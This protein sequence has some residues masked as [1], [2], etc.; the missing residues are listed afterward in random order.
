MRQ[1]V[2]A[3]QRAAQSLAVDLVRPRRGEPSPCSPRGRCSPAPVPTSRPTPP[4]PSTASSV[5]PTG[6][7]LRLALIGDSTAAGVGVDLTEDTVGA[8]LA[9]AIA[10]DRRVIL[11]GVAIAGSRTGDLGPQVSRALL[12]RPDVVVMLI[13]ANDATHVTP[14]ATGA[15]ASRLPPSP[16]CAPKASPSSS[17]PAPTWA[18]ATSCRRCAR[19]WPGRAA[20][21]PGAGARRTRRRRRGRAA[22]PDLRAAVPGRPRV[23][24]RATGST[25]PRTATG[26][27][28]RRCCRPCSAPSACRPPAEKPVLIKPSRP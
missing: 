12:G 15:A 5:I 24:V 10:A 18:P 7:P 26:S 16:G 3:P 14:L 27:G 8:Q 19:W 4:R 1:G 2:N 25:R 11:T 6:V 13:G 20:G 22:R 28:P 23:A 9:A 21:S 17:A